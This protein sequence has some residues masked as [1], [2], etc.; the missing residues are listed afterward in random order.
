MVSPNQAA[1]GRRRAESRLTDECRIV[2]RTRS[3]VLDEHG[4]YSDTEV[5][6]YAGPCVLKAVNVFPNAVDAAGQQL[7]LQSLELGLPIEG[8]ENVARDQIV[9][10]TGSQNDEA[11]VGLEFRIEGPSERQSYATLRRFRA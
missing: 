7:V 11:Q 1:Q 10:I 5:E 8:S 4:D 6:H 9:V 2:T 3:D